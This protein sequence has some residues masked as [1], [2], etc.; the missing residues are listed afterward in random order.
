MLYE[1][2]AV[3]AIYESHSEAEK[4]LEWNSRKGWLR[5][6]EEFAD[7]SSARIITPRRTSSGTTIPVTA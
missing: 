6:Y 1:K 5:R 3:V 7:R 2:N 4:A